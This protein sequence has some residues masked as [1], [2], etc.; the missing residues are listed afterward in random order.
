MNTVL[1]SLS[2]IAAALFQ[3]LRLSYVVPAFLFWGL[4][5]IFILPN[6]PPWVRQPLHQIAKT[7]GLQKATMVTIASLLTGYFLYVLNVQ[8]IRWFEGYQWFEWPLLKSLAEEK[9]SCHQRYRLRLVSELKKQLELRKREISKWEAKK[10]DFRIEDP[11][12]QK[13]FQRTAQLET[14]LEVFQAIKTK[15]IQ[16][17]YPTSRESFLPTSLGNVIASF[18]DYPHDHYGMDAV[19]LWP[20]LAPILSQQKYSLFLEREKANLDFLLN[21]CVALL[22][23]SLELVICGSLYGQDIWLWLSAAGFTVVISYAVFYR[24]SIIG[25]LSW[26]Q[27]V[28]VA[29]DLY[30]YELLAALCGRAPKN[31]SEEKTFWLNISDFFRKSGAKGPP[32]TLD[33]KKVKEVIAQM[34]LTTKGENK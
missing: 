19:T 7:F 28:R 32:P 29:F 10:A 20:R 2:E 11:K 18:E 24:T 1:G 27:S 4:N 13:I 23:F 3:S 8:V 6:L 14:E 5:A 17:L 30:R 9:R 15:N 12:R 22:L 26:G 21:T 16:Y 33:Y 31:F 34:P 25:A